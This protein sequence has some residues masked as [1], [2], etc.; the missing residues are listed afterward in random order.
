MKVLVTGS[1]GF[2]GFHTAKR[3]LERGDSVVGLDIV[4]DYYDP[5]IKE[6]RLAVLEETAART[7][8]GYSFIRANLA[9]QTN[10]RID[11]HWASQSGILQGMG[12]L[13]LPDMVLREGEIAE[14]LARLAAQ[15]GLEAPA[16]RAA[17]PDGP[18]ALDEIYDADLEALAR[19]AYPRDYLMLGFGN[20]R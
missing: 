9:G 1:A 11:P 17:A 7:N 6:A 14:G 13:C 12:D 20:W 2:V 15:V 19:A 10:L 3:L 16:P 5:A 18:I 4:N 8:A